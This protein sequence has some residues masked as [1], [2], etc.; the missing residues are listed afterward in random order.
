MKF[1]LDFE[2][3]RFSNRIISI[4]CAAENGNTFYTLVKPVNK[5]KVDRFITELTGITN[6]M[7]AAAP[8]ADE[9]FNQLFDFIELNSCGIAPEFY[10]YGDSDV[11]FIQH[12]VKY[13]EDTRA[14]MCALAIGGNFIDY[15][16]IVK[17]FFVVKSDMALRK[18]Y[19][20]IK[21]KEELVQEHNA[22]EDALMLQCVVENLESKCRP[23]DK[24]T[25]LAMPSQNKPKVGGKA[26]LIFQE[27]NKSNVSKWDANTL[28][29]ENCWMFKCVDQHSHNIKY[30][31]SAE[32][33]ALWIIKYIARNMSPKNVGHVKKIAAAV[34]AAPQSG[35]CRYNCHWEYNPEGAIT[36]LAND[37]N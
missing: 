3:T 26:P 29:D 2:A 34:A 37:N 12:T 14:C 32:T 9:A 24:D 28:A 35:K 31:D 8:T 20:L 5:A 17:K 21:A 23:E 1:Y 18:V 11:V 15:A 30:F 19:M 6:D 7:L 33:A 25:I 16:N 27:W 36:L 10:C 22:L 4:G 13:M